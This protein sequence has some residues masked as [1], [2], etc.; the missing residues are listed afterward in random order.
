MAV[1]SLFGAATDRSLLASLFIGLFVALSSTAIVHKELSSHNQPDAPHGRLTV[2]VL[3]FQ[4]L[5]VVVLLL[6]VPLLLGQTPLTRVPLVFGRALLLM[7]LVVTVSRFVLPVILGAVAR[8][9]RREAF[10]LAVMV[11]SIGTAWVSSLLGISMALGAFLGGLVLAE[12][13]FSHQTHAE[14]RPLRDLLAGLFFISLRMLIH[15]PFIVRQL[16]SVAAITALIIVIKTGAAAAALRLIGTPLRIAV[17]AGIGLAQVGEFS[18]ILGR[19]G[20]QAG[21]LMPTDWQM[22]L[23]ASI[24]TMVVTPAMIGV[25]PRIALRVAGRSAR[26]SMPDTDTEIPELADHVVILGFG[27]GGQLVARA[28]RDPETP[29]LVL[30]LSGAS[31]RRG[32]LKGEPIFFGDATSPDALAAAGVQRARAVVSV[33]SDPDASV[34]AVRAVRTLVPL[35]PVIVRARYRTEADL[36]LRFRAT[37]A[38]AE[39]F[40][41]SLEVLTQLLARMQVPGNAVEMLLENFRRGATGQQPVRAASRP[42]ARR[43]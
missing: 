11:A 16:P 43:Y 38:I 41:G 37:T 32:R 1:L 13:E 15:M 35:V 19:A 14:I 3:L 31:V 6:L 2:S 8:S 5:S 25:A 26:S 18:F 9:G 34:L 12:S 17:T 23:A 30:E 21:L 40:E 4:D 20:L 39:E 24:A 36:L 10:S 27:I 7:V 33:L 29:Y 22:L 28:L 42:L